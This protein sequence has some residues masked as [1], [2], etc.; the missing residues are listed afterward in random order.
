MNDS[1]LG[2]FNG[3][4]KPTPEVGWAMYQ[5]AVDFNNSINLNNTVKVN[6]NFFVGKVCRH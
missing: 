1:K 5:K 4:D 2:L 3:E 6:E